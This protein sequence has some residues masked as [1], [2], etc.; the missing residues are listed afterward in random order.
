MRSRRSPIPPASRMVDMSMLASR[1]VSGRERVAHASCCRAAGR[2]IEHYSNLNHWTVQVGGACRPNA[3][4]GHAIYSGSCVVRGTRH[5]A[6]CRLCHDSANTESSLYERS[7]AISRLALPPPGGARCSSEP[8]HHRRK[9]IDVVYFTQISRSSTGPGRLTRA[10]FLPTT[11]WS[12]TSSPALG[13]KSCVVA[14][15]LAL[16]CTA[17]RDR[18][19]VVST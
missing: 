4:V 5:F 3:C 13:H 2:H 19:R 9:L 7:S 1:R 11:C 17:W 8:C 10:A 18:M 16:P 15:L 14:G 6:C 12:R